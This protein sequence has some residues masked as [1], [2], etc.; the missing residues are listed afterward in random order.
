LG[1]KETG[2]IWLAIRAHFSLDTQMH[3]LWLPAAKA[4][5]VLDGKNPTLALNDLQ[6]ASSS[7]LGRIQF[8]NNIPCLYAVTYRSS[9][10][11][12]T[13]A[14]SCMACRTNRESKAVKCNQ[15]FVLATSIML[16]SEEVR[17]LLQK[18]VQL[19]HTSE[20]TR[21]QPY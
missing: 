7:E 3:P 17:R 12:A 1:L 11:P 19:P 4:Q 18:S 8:V 5:L 15:T 16:S 14:P 20:V 21:C 13:P 2:A 9:N 6:A 10:S